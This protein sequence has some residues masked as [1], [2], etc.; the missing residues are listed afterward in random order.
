MTSS[1]IKVR[2]AVIGLGKM[3]ANHA[4]VYS[5]MDCATLV[6]V[7]DVNRARAVEGAGTY[8][9][10]AFATLDEVFEAGV[11]AV[12]VAVPTTLHGEISI[13]ALERGMHVL[14]EK[15]IAATREEAT[16][17]I[18]VARRFGRKLM[19]G[20]IERFNPAVQAIK[21]RVS[22]EE[23]I[24]INLM[25][26]GPLPPRIKDAG[27]I[28][29]FGVHDIDLVHFLCESQPKTVYCVRSSNLSQMEDSASILL[30]MRGGAAAQITANWITPYKAREIQVITAERLIKGNLI[31]Q[32]V[33]EYS[34]YT[35]DGYVVQDVSVRRHEPLR[36]E[37]ASFLESII[38]DGPTSVTGS[39]GLRA[40]DVATQASTY[41]Q[42]DAVAA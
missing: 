41:R 19:V 18:R 32:Q 21:A 29:D 16:E 28:I 7:F 10:R 1:N 8:G 35:S 11:D 40:L 15:P 12:T 25:R 38:Q 34:R 42:L 20:H 33:Q 17:M 37:L 9:C 24:S 31:T 4:R 5:E 2:T 6:G 30:E 23:I 22:P 39:D 26:V 27:V 13:A 3:G 36:A 14:V